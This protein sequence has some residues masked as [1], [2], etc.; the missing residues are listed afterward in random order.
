MYIY[1]DDHVYRS[2]SERHCVHIHGRSGLALTPRS[3]L[4][5]H[6]RTIRFSA[7]TAITTVYTYTDDHVYRSHSDHHCVHI[8]GRSGLALTPRSPL[9]THTQTIRFSTHTSITTVY[10]YTDDQVYRSHSDHHCVHIHGRSGLALTPRSPLCTHTQTIRFSTHT[11]ITTVYT[12]TD[13][14]V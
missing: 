13:D 7:H 10:T 11:S 4:C 8:H 3:P 12:Y 14:Q 2:H 5:T 1:T 6:T 9:C